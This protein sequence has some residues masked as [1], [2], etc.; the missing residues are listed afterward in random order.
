MVWRV[1]YNVDPGP[2]WFIYSTDRKERGKVKAADDRWFSSITK[3]L[4]SKGLNKFI[5][6]Y[7]QRSN[8]A[9]KRKKN[10]S[11]VAETT[12]FIR[13]YSYIVK[14]CFFLDI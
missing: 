11:S 7:I 2:R 12:F 8:L 14:K 4:T 9:I 1:Q 5:L 3:R 6:P 13:R 10:I